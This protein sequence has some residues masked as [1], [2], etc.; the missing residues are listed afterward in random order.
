MSGRRRKPGRLYWLWTF[1]VGIYSPRKG[2]RRIAAD[3]AA[4]HARIEELE[5]LNEEMQRENEIL[6]QRN[7]KVVAERNHLQAVLDMNA[8]VEACEEVKTAAK[9]A[10]D[11]IPLRV[12]TPWGTTDPGVIH[13]G[14]VD[15]HNEAS[16]QP[17]KVS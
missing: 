14:A 17:S 16:K 8:D 11:T 2:Q 6:R 9:R 12:T 15:L 3:R 5:V 13:T 7:G 10:A 1:A 4:D